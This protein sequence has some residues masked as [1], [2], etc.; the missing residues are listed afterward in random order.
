MK[1]L[2]AI[3]QTNGCPQNGIIHEFK[4]EVLYTVCGICSQE[5]TDLVITDIEEVTD[6]SAEETV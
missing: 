2:K 1:N 3:C 5:I 6:G 4:S